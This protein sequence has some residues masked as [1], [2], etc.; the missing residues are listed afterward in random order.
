MRTTRARYRKVHGRDVSPRIDRRAED[1]AQVEYAGAMM[2]RSQAAGPWPRRRARRSS[3]RPS[4]S[5]ANGLVSRTRLELGPRY[6][7]RKDHGPADQDGRRARL[8]QW[9]RRSVRTATP[10]SG[11]AWY[12]ACRFFPPLAMARARRAARSDKRI[13]RPGLRN[14]R[15]GPFRS[16]PARRPHGDSRGV[17]ATWSQEDRRASRPR[18]PLSLWGGPHADRV[19]AGSRSASQD[20]I[21]GFTQAL[22]DRSPTPI[23]GRANGFADSD[24][25]Q[26]PLA[27]TAAK[28]RWPA[29]WASTAGEHGG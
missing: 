23:D 24:G 16:P 13:P 6:W 19:A 15:F 11:V 10:R 29:R 18:A 21:A 20:S 1:A 22:G 3:S 8:A 25:G 27:S 9:Q 2:F 12:M 5:R 17:S 26:G 14:G 28:D 4:T 7:R